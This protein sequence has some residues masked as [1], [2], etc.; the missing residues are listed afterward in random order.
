MTVRTAVETAAA[1]RGGQLSPSDAVAL[2]LGRITAYDDRLGAFQLVRAERALAE[3]AQLDRRA[4]LAD[5]PLAGVPIAIK[6]NVP[7]TGEPMRDG[8]LATSP[9]PQTHDHPVVARLRAAGA[10][11][12]GI[13]RTP[14]LCVWAASD[15]PFGVAKNPWDVT[16]TPGGSSGGSAAAVAAGLVPVAHGNDGLGSIRIPG[17]CCG[18]VGIKPGLG[19]VP[20]E[21]GANDW[22]SMTENGPLATTV[23]DLALTLSVMAGQPG[24]AAVRPPDR[25]LRIGVSV[26]P[27]LLG[28]VL[29]DG[30]ADGVRRSADAFSDLGH[31]VED[32]E[33]PYPL[34]TLPALMRWF[35]GASMD[36][37]GL[38]RKAL[39]RRTRMHVRFGDVVRRLDLVKTAQRDAW[40]ARAEGWFRR[41]DVLL[42]PTLAQPPIAAT[43]W[44]RGSWP[45]SMWAHA[46]YAPYPATWN[47]LGWPGMTVPAGI[48]PQAGTPVGVQLVSPPG[49]EVVLLGLAAQLE[50]R[51]PWPRIAHGYGT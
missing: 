16:R 24:Y 30:W 15:S 1:V 31:V 18:L 21:V 40:V 12:V 4:D 32:A 10:V 48:H 25:P 7:V 37:D 8:S 50:D 44:G 14:E 11:V 22:Y 23:A 33:Y 13:T 47:V 35:A 3:A 26:R 2:S 43:E 29:D 51:R 20:A 6:D 34:N 46:R 5:L 38:D 19:V 45:A 28:A 17:A 41:Y 27:P 49:G 39:Q 42:T 9:A 36:A